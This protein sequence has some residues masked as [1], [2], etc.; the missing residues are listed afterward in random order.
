M[1]VHIEK[2][3][4]IYSDGRHNAFTSICRWRGKY[5]IAF[6]SALSH[7]SP[8]DIGWE[9]KALQGGCIKLLESVDLQSWSASTVIDTKYDDRDAKL[10]A[11]DT[12]LLV[13]ATTIGKGGRQQTWMSYT[14]DGAHWRAPVKAYASDYAFWQPKEHGGAYYVAADIDDSPTGTEVAERGRVD[15]LRSTD[16][17]DWQRVSTITAGNCC[18]ETDLVFL[19]DG[20]GLAVVRQNLLAL[21][22]APYTTWKEHRIDPKDLRLGFPGPAAVQL[23][24]VVIIVCRALCDD[25]VDLGKV[26]APDCVTRIYTLD[27]ESME[28]IGQADLPARWNGDLSYAGILRQ[29]EDRLVVSSYDGEKYEGGVFKRSD[30]MLASIRVDRQAT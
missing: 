27:V 2:V 18:T 14:E 9:D 8:S 30:I 26:P 20:R 11:T 6:R 22:E 4:T 15:L 16:G 23:G 19:R 25:S 5:C 12:R 24:E 29:G 17:I 7:A 3:E 13:Y 10:L 21:A 1:K 28:L